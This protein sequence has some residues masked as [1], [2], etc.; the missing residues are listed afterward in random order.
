MRSQVF[1][2]A[3]PSPSKV[4]HELH[5]VVEGPSAR[6]DEAQQGGEVQ[7]YAREFE[8]KK[9]DERGKIRVRLRQEL[10]LRQPSMTAALQGGKPEEEEEE[11]KICRIVMR[12][13]TG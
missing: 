2:N 5:L 7:V 11:P 12:L 9:R 6:L 1:T 10:H 8:V 3:A 13:L 4:L